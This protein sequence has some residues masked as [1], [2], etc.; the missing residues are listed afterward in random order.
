[1]ALSSELMLMFLGNALQFANRDDNLRTQPCLFAFL[2][3]FFSHLRSFFGGGACVC[4]QAGTQ[5]WDE[6]LQSELL[7]GRLSGTAFDR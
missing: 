7:Q 5:F 3:L 2:F 1:M 6:N 4:V